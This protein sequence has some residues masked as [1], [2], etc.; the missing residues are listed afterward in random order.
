MFHI[1]KKFLTIPFFLTV[2]RFV[3]MPFLI[4]ALMYHQWNAA[5]CLFTFAAMTDVLD[6]AFARL[7]NEETTLGA[8]LDPIGDKILTVTTFGLLAFDSTTSQFVPAWLFYVILAKELLLIMGAAYVLRNK[9]TCVIHAGWAGKAAMFIQTL[10]VFIILL[11]LFA[12]YPIQNVQ[13]IDAMHAVIVA[14]LVVALLYYVYQL[15]QCKR[16]SVPKGAAPLVILL[17]IVPLLHA[18]TSEFTMATPVKKNK[19]SLNQV[20][21]DSAEQLEVLAHNVAHEIE[22]A[23]VLLRDVMKSIRDVAE[24]DTSSG[25]IAYLKC[26]KEDCSVAFEAL[27]DATRARTA[28]LKAKHKWFEEDVFSCNLST[29]RGMSH[30]DTKK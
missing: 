12:E 8:Y 3:T 27:D 9:P 21:Q 17:L 22:A 23:S 16:D 4:V 5:L 6:G 30:R 2:A 29:S 13:A 7:F 25:A 24:G 10:F 1:D 11:T 19:R 14:S 18:Q 28:Q 20:R 26:R 15:I